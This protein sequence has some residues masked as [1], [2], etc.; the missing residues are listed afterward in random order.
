ME[1]KVYAGHLSG[2]ISS[3]SGVF[4]MPQIGNR[5]PLFLALYFLALGDILPWNLEALFT[6]VVITKSTIKLEWH[7]Q[8]SVHI[9]WHMACDGLAN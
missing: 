2:L 8:D 4:V 9:K 1:L 5:I 7:I 6:Y 3:Q